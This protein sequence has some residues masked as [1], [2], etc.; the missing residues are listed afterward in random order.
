M[1]QLDAVI[2]GAGPAGSAAARALAR[3]GA[4]VA[5][6]DA[7]HPREKPCGGGLTARALAI[8]GTTAAGAT[9]QIV[10]RLVFSHVAN[11]SAAGRSVEVALS[12]SSTLQVC[13]RRTFD[14]ALLSDAVA[15]G[16]IHV[17]ARAARLDTDVRGWTVETGTERLSAPWIVGADGASSTVRKRVFRPFE[18]KHLSIA[19]G[20]FVAGTA[21]RDVAIAFTARPSGYLWSFPRPDHL[22]VGA[23]AQ[24]DETSTRELH[25]ICDRWL[26]AYAPAS[27]KPRTRYAWPI[28]S[29]DASALDGER[30]AGDA[31]MLVGDAAGLVDPITREGIYFALRSGELAA[32]ALGRGDPARV[33]A[34]AI[35]DEIH[36]ELKRA[37]RLKAGFYRP[38]FT[39]LLI[40]ALAESAAIRGVMVD[41]VAGRQPYAG[42]KRR[43]LTTFELGLMLEVLISP[44]TRRARGR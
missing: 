23:C 11:G 4:R 39:S 29:L 17:A 40:D 15:A 24:A 19:A 30:P 26:D 3:H 41:L 14:A 31:W 10:D 8:A 2:I 33:Y 34:E 44:Y 6:L 25:G 16:A 36:P 18:R 27:G 38:R 21:R 1:T 12:D 13:S 43:L 32:E 20:S 28:P 22:A 7:S 42:L 5:I 37:A 35:R 9:G